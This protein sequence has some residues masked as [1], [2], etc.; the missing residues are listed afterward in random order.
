MLEILSAPFP[1]RCF[2]CDE[3]V[4]R[5]DNYIL[6]EG[7]RMCLKCGLPERRLKKLPRNVSAPSEPAGEQKI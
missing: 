3:K 5:G 7:Y 2:V 1:F 6:K 4:S